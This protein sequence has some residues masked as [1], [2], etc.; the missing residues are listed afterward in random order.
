M[1]FVSGGNKST[2]RRMHELL[3][4]QST[5][6][7][8]TFSIVDK[9]DDMRSDADEARGM[10]TW[11]VYHIENYLLDS[12]VILRVFKRISL[13]GSTFER[14][15]GVE[16][17]LKAIAE[18]QIESMVEDWVRRLAHKKIGEAIKLRGGAV[19]GSLAATK[20]GRNVSESAQ[21]TMDLATGDL[22]ESV[23]STT[24]TE[25]RQ[26]LQSAI[27]TPN[28]DWKKVFRGRDI[29]KKF[30]TPVRPQDRL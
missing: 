1:N 9:D 23:L 18:E 22:S 12:N 30:V 19:D 3:E 10:Y 28:N 29:L 4:A 14:D 8:T 26:L 27:G 25:R 20:V 7:R 11:D 13:D 21:R 16:A 6:Q 5:G 17:A 15:V 2:V 24:A